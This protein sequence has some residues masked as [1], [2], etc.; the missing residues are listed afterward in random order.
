MFI[1]KF[2][3][4]ASLHTVVKEYYYLNIQAERYPKSIPIIDDCCYDFIFFKEAMATLYYGTTPTKAL[5]KEKF[6]TIHGLTPPYKI[7]FDKSLTF[8]TIKLQP[9]CNGYFFKQLKQKGIHS[10]EPHGV[11]WLDFYNE[12]FNESGFEQKVTLANTIMTSMNVQHTHSMLLV[13]EICERIDRKKGIVTVNELSEHFKISR[14]YLNRIFKQEVLYTLKFYITA[15]RIL[16]LVKYKSKN[17]QITL[18]ELSYEYGY[19]DQPHFIADFKK[20]CG[21]TPS[22]FFNNLPEFILRH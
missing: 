11:S 8:F 10:L 15:V 17:Q 22:H 3:T 1:K 4:S 18:I 14:Q 2:K 21:V 5:I 13:K 12:I 7:S 9:W 6:F 19:F 20:V 16:D